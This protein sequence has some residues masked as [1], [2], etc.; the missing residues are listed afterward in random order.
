MAE[1]YFQYK[2]RAGDVQ[3][4]S[5][6]AA[7]RYDLG[8]HKKT[9]LK[10]AGCANSRTLLHNDVAA[11]HAG[12]LEAEY[13]KHCA[14]RL[15]DIR[16]RY[17]TVL[18]ELVPLYVDK[19]IT[20]C[21]DMKSRLVELF[22]HTKVWARGVIGVELVSIEHLKAIERQ[23]ANEKRK[24]TVVSDLIPLRGLE[25]LLVKNATGTMALVHCHVLVDLGGIEAS[26]EDAFRS[27]IQRVNYWNQASYQIEL[28][29]TFKHRSLRK[30]LS[31]ISKYATKGGNEQLRYKSGFGR[32]LAEDLDAKIWRAGSGRKD[33]GG[34]TVEDN[35]GLTVGEVAFL[36]AVYRRLMDLKRNK[37][38]YVVSSR[39]R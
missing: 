29:R 13:R 33:R 2:K 19:V 17:L 6:V 31:G 24:L 34:D 4:Q 23:T 20:S 37:K 28:K 27:A 25:G 1:T 14:G 3:F 15:D 22:S 9:R 10:K 18:H 26:R 35:R 16:L 5:I 8:E 12:T 30:N 38:G 32:D 7:L 36:D 39:G 21:V 11:D